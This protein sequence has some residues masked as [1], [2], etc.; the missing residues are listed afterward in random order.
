MRTIK[1]VKLV[2]LSIIATFMSI[3]FVFLSCSP[4]DLLETDCDCGT[5]VSKSSS[6][7]S[8]LDLETYYKLTIESYCGG[9]ED[10]L[11]PR[12]IYESTSVGDSYCK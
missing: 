9:E 5:V 3:G 1:L 6:R 12:Y 7:L 2:R 4:D 11:V 8:S 10:K